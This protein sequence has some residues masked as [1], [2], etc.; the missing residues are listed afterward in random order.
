M[1][2]RKTIPYT[3]NCWIPG[4]NLLCVTRREPD[5]PEVPFPPR[6]ETYRGGGFDNTLKPFWTVGK[7][8]RVPGFLATSFSEAVADK[9]IGWAASPD[10]STIKW[11]IKFDPRGKEEYKYRCKQVNLVKKSVSHVPGEEEYLFAPY[12]AFTVEEVK[13]ASDPSEEHR[14]VLRAAVDNRRE[15]DDLPLCPWY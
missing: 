7:Q 6:C 5:M 1:R 3:P 4:I 9:F 10:G 13:W 2:G 12:S 15:S 8:Y 14:V 11:V